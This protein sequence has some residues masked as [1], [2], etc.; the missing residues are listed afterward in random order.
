MSDE[1]TLELAPW[2]NACLAAMLFA[3]DPAGTGGV[4][5]RGLSGPVRDRW[6]ALLRTLLGDDVP[7]RRLPLHVTDDRLLG[8]LDLT[9]TLQAGRPIAERGLL[10]ESD[11]GVVVAAMAERLEASTTAQLG[12]A[13]DRGEVVLERD[14]LTSRFPARLG[15]VALDEGLEPDERAPAALADR[16]AF[17]VDLTPLTLRETVDL[18]VDPA[19]VAAARRLVPDVAV[20]P[21]IVEALCKAAMAL[22]VVSLRGPILALRVARAAAAC[23]GRTDVEPADVAV[24]ARLVLAPRAT[25]WPSDEA[26]ADEPQPE[27]EDEERDDEGA[28]PAQ[29]LDR[30]LDDVVLE[31]AM[32]AIP[33]GLLALLRAGDPVR[34][35]SAGH[36]AAGAK[37]TSKLRGRPLGTRR[38]EPTGGKRLSVVETLRAAA[39]WQPLRRSQRPNRANAGVDV[40][41]DDFRIR[42]FA[43]RTESTAIFVVDASGS[44]ALHRLAE[45]KGAVEL[46][47]ADCY[48]RRDRVALVAF[49]GKSAELVLPPTRSLVRA[50]RSLAGLPGG[51]GTPLAT[52]ID[53]AMALAELVRRQG[54]TPVLVFL[55]DGRANVGR[56]GVG[57]RAHAQADADLAASALAALGAS[58]LLIDTAPKPQPQAATLATKMQARYLALPHADATAVSAAVR[59]SGVME[60][61]P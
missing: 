37:K 44:S 43:D 22:G 49:R 46:L 39:P 13:L 51:G 48:V 26:P 41:S 21:E 30:P 61:R 25:M 36:G 7:L 8:G 10:A 9:R 38:G 12:A 1:P 3:V 27:A 29:E 14:G 17:H 45:A 31:A 4:L 23:E 28:P 32:A 5:L 20:A 15:V 40:R 52:A 33:E 16:L 34:L 60:A 35:Q 2:G 56:D 59:A 50:K 57:G 55:T 53:A 42:R 6:L 54:Q 47:L 58:S 24:A 19:E 18:G 11:G